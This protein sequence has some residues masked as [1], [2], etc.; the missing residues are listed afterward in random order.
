MTP[1]VSWF[2]KG[3]LVTVIFFLFYKLLLRR[4]TFFKWSR[5]Y[6]VLAIL[7]SFLIPLI[8]VSKIIQQPEQSISLF[9]YIPNLSF[10]QQT[11]SANWSSILLNNLLF[12]GMLVMLFRL[13]IQFR[14]LLLL[15]KNK[16]ILAQKDFRI[17]ELKEPVNPFS[18]FNDIYVNPAIHTEA[19]LQEIIRHEQFHVQ[20]KH[21]IDILLGEILTIVFWFNPFAWLLK[22][23]L[24]QNLEF[25]TDKLVLESGIDAKHYQYNLLKVS[26]IQN[27][28]AAANHFH[29]LKLKNRIIMMNKK[30]TRPYQLAKYLLLVPVVAV[31][32]MA[33]SNRAEMMRAIKQVTIADISPVKSSDTD[34]IP[35]KPSVIIPDG[36]SSPKPDDITTI[37]IVKKDGVKKATVVLKNGKTEVY[38]LSDPHQKKLFDEKYGELTTPPTPPVPPAKT[39]LPDDVIMKDYIND[40]GEQKIIIQHKNGKKETYN[41]SNPKEKKLYEEKYGKLLAPPAPDGLIPA[42]DAVPPAPPVIIADT[43]PKQPK[44]MVVVDGIAMPVEYNVS[45]ID[46]ST[47]KEVNVLKGD[48][49]IAIYGEKG[50]NGVIQVS[51]KSY[52]TKKALLIVDGKEMSW[53]DFEAKYKPEQIKSMNVL[54]GDKAT[55]KYGDKAKEGAIEVTLK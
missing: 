23:E 29:F 10:T 53:N 1:L 17:I 28:I 15:R 50:N 13:I 24:K 51:T 39:G 22:N 26:G 44:P 48:A 42:T 52:T 54:K 27:N 11:S 38:D 43:A 49:A 6:F 33:F 5:W 32:L 40:R 3:S 2:V 21:T 41:L 4:D 36:L 30:Q 8:D 20:Q 16:T 37:N 7:C 12:A 25:L 46:P 55:S 14:A 31:M 45:K 18:F 34:V 35:D 47:I 19:E 9:N